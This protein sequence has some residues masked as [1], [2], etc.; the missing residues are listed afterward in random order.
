MAASAGGGH[1]QFPS[2]YFLQALTIS[3]SIRGCQVAHQEH[4][5]NHGRQANKPGL[6]EGAAGGRNPEQ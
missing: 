1:R 4:E 6:V 3:V 2:S 5:G